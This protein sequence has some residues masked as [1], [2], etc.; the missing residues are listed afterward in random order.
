MHIYIPKLCKEI[1]SGSQTHHASSRADAA[2]HSGEH[3]R[4]T[5]VCTRLLNTSSLSLSSSPSHCSISCSFP[6]A[7][8]SL[9][10]SL[11]GLFLLLD[12]PFTSGSL[13][14]GEEEAGDVR[15]A[16]ASATAVS[17]TALT[18]LAISSSAASRTT[19]AASC[20]RPR[21]PRRRRAAR[22]PYRP[23]FAPS[24]ATGIAGIWLQFCWMR[25]DRPG[26]RH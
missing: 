17:L 18:V 5:P 21:A 2:C 9:Y 26:A 12:D 1:Y 6:I 7:A 13:Y 20:S 15:A 23:A 10:S 25:R 14:L 8:A 22:A 3:L 19:A 16:V 4:K 11:A 24:V